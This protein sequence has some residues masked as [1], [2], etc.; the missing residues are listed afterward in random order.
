M[1]E[2]GAVVPVIDRTYPLAEAP[3]AVR[4]LELEHARA[5]VVITVVQP[6]RPPRPRRGTTSAFTLSSCR[7]GIPCDHGKARRSLNRRGD[8]AARE[9]ATSG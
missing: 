2:S 9:A 1:A 6:D 4:Y 8:R 3:A 7:G 5:E